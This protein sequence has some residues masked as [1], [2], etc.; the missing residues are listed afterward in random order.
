M[1]LTL[2]TFEVRKPV[3]WGT[4]GQDVTRQHA[5]SACKPLI[6]LDEG[7]KAYSV[8]APRRRWKASTRP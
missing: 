6:I 7:H 2:N 5:A 1:C 8:K 4:A 3:V